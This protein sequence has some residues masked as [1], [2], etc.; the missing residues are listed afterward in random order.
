[1]CLVVVVVLWGRGEWRRRG[2]SRRRGGRGGRGGK[3][4]V[5]VCVWATEYGRT[6]L[7]MQSLTDLRTYLRRSYARKS[8]GLMDV[9][10]ADLWTYPRRSYGCISGGLMD[11]TPTDRRASILGLMP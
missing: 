6:D 3:G 5:C 8:D 4:G 1:M 9:S 11:V 2:K 7:R 10:P